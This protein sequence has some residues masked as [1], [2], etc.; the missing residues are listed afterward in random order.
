MKRK[1]F[2]AFAVVLLSFGTLHAEPYAPLLTPP[3]GINE[4]DPV[5]RL[6]VSYLKSSKVPEAHQVPVP[7]YPGAVVTQVAPTDKYVC[8]RLLSADD[9]QKVGKF[10]GAR[11]SGWKTRH[12][13]SMGIFTFWEGA[14]DPFQAGAGEGKLVEITPVKGDR[15]M[16]SARTKIGIFYPAR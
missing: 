13:E 7:A 2:L 16:P 5:T 3:A 12:M 9:A 4:N 11:L 14:D 10:Y 1:A 15:L 8:I 6:S